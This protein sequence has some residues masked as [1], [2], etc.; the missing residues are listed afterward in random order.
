[1]A[2]HS[3]SASADR[4][5]YINAMT[6]GRTGAEIDDDLQDEATALWSEVQA[7]ALSD[8]KPSLKTL[9]GRGSGQ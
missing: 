9:K 4:L 1:M 5:P 7:L 3:A 6:A 2:R 8:I